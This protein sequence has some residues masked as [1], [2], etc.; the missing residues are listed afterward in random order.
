MNTHVTGNFG[1][2][3]ICEP[4]VAKHVRVMKKSRVIQFLVAALLVSV[5]CVALLARAPNYVITIFFCLPPV[6]LLRSSELARP[7]ARPDFWITIGVLA[8]FLALIIL[9]N[10]FAQKSVTEDFVYHPL[11]VAPLW[12]TMLCALLWRWR[13]ERR[14]IS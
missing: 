11:F 9:A 2:I 8:V 4:S 12:I 14:E 7:V 5:G 3:S 1:R 13:R 10:F 6:V